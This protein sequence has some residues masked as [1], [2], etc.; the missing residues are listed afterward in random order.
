MESAFSIDTFQVIVFA[1]NLNIK[2]IAGRS[3]TDKY[4]VAGGVYPLLFCINEIKGENL[5]EFVFNLNE[6]AKQN[7]GESYYLCVDLEKE[8][9]IPISNNADPVIKFLTEFSL[10]GLVVFKVR[11]LLVQHPSMQFI[12]NYCNYSQTSAVFLLNSPVNFVSGL[13]QLQIRLPAVKSNLTLLSKFDNEVISI[14]NSIVWRKYLSSKDSLFNF[15]FRSKS[16]KLLEL[17]YF[18]ASTISLN[19]E[20]HGDLSATVLLLSALSQNPYIRKLDLD[21]TFLEKPILKIFKLLGQGDQFRYGLTPPTQNVKGFILLCS[22]LKI[23]QAVEYK[24]K[25]LTSEFYSLQLFRQYRIEI[26]KDLEADYIV[27]RR[28]EKNKFLRREYP[29]FNRNNSWTLGDV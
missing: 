16:S 13:K 23:E 28:N 17:G 22:L 27:M 24:R 2:F 14:S 11:T 1:A 25:F 12:I 9:K 20:N 18:S 29:F 19:L 6:N 15:N 3:R 4:Y 26:N 10:Y 5:Q 8:G 21:V 7:L